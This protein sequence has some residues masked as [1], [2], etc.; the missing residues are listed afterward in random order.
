MSDE[1]NTTENTSERNSAFSTQH[2]KF[3]EA[4]LESAIIEPGE[5]EGSNDELL[6][7]SHEYSNNLSNP[8]R[9]PVKLSGY[10]RNIPQASKS[11]QR[12]RH[13]SRQMAREPRRGASKGS[14]EGVKRKI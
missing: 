9:N 2:S 7:M 5:P 12:S 14:L 8:D 11:G 1:L 3:T 10:A 13:Q 6:V 4:Q